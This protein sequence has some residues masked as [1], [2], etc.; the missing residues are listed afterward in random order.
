M[1][2]KTF[3]KRVALWTAIIAAVIMLIIGLCCGKVI[4]G[5]LF[6]EVAKWVFM[7]LIVTVILEGFAYFLAPLYWHFKVDPSR[8]K[9]ET[10][11]EKM[12]REFRENEGL[13][14]DSC[15]SETCAY[16]GQNIC[17]IRSG[18]YCPMYIRKKT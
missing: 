11:V 4:E 15:A 5:N 7:W 1:D 2:K 13:L 18:E 8:K 16:R 12:R 17:T 14:E 10:P 6:A 9:V 3:C